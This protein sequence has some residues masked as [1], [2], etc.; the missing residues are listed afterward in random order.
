MYRVHNE[1]ELESLVTGFGSHD[2][3]RIAVT[4]NRTH[5]LT[6]IHSHTQIYTYQHN[7]HTTLHVYTTYTNTYPY[8]LHI[9]IYMQTHKHILYIHTRT[10]ANSH[11]YINLCTHTTTPISLYIIT[12]INERERGGQRV[13]PGKEEG[14]KTHSKGQGPTI[15]DQAKSAQQNTKF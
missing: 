2:Q 10:H 1:H 15:G 14:M 13:E 9:H 7:L 4:R 11:T 12:H 3:I 5:K 6:H 8:T